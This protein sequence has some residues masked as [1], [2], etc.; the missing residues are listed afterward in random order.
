MP[1]VVTPAGNAGGGRGAAAAGTA[2]GAANTVAMFT[3]VGMST[4]TEFPR[5]ALT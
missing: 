2:A 5:A 3:A 4:L 1:I